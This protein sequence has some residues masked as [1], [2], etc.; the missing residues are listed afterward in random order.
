[1][2]VELTDV[3]IFIPRIR[4]ELEPG[5][6]ASGSVPASAYSDNTLKDVAADAVGELQ[7]IGGAS[8]PYTLSIQETTPA[9]AFTPD[10]WEYETDPA[11]PLILHNLVAVQAALT[12]VYRE[13]Q[14]FKSAEKISDEGSSWEVQRASSLM[15]ARIDFLLQRR[16]EILE[17]LKFD[18][19]ELVTDQFVNLLEER[20]NAL[21]QA[22]E[23]YFYNPGTG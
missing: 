6:V 7:L 17:R 14:S 9:S 8:F 23:P 16:K 22:I 15:K 20:S 2:P 18:N 1:M 10:A 11:V 19:P 5:P 3:R 12:Q 13:A 4:R 21:D